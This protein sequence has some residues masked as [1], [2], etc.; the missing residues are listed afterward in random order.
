MIPI[1]KLSF[2]SVQTLRPGSVALRRVKGDAV[3]HLIALAN[4]QRIQIPL[5][6]GRGG[7][8]VFELT[9]RESRFLCIDKVRFSV[10]EATCFADLDDDDVGCLFLSNEKWGL[11]SRWNDATVYIGLDGTELP[12]PEWGGFVGFRAWKVE[13]DGPDEKPVIIY[14]RKV[15][16][17][18]E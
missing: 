13:F 17:K 9:S 3:P 1:E 5:T 10:D 12:E 8:C 16:A 4:E 15:R 2:H 6:D 7:L 18:N 14:E 11:I